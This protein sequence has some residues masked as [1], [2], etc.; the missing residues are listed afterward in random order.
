[1]YYHSL[2]N[3]HFNLKGCGYFLDTGYGTKNACVWRTGTIQ[4]LDF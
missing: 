1:M 4:A 2:L 3:L